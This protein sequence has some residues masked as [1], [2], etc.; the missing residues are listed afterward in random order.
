M[1]NITN[2]TDDLA[3]PD[4]GSSATAVSAPA[5][6]VS[7]PSATSSFAAALRERPPSLHGAGELPHNQPFSGNLKPDSYFYIT[8]Y[9]ATGEQVCEL[10]LY[11]K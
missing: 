3:L 5:A 4:C 2:S 7:P 6:S 9:T 8:D 11:I 10:N 1:Y